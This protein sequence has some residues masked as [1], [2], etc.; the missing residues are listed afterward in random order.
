MGGSFLGLRVDKLAVGWIGG[1]LL[2]YTWFAPRPDMAKGKA[3]YAAPVFFPSSLLLGIS[4]EFISSLRIGLGLDLNVT[5]TPSI[6]RWWPA[7]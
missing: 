1:C 6:K 4:T 2:S 7:V 5:S 3:K